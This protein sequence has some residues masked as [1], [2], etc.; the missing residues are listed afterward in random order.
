MRDD[1]TKPVGA[2]M[3]LGGGIAGMQTSLDLAESGI[4]V[5][6]VERSPS[7]GGR[8]AQL[9]KTFPTNDCAMC[10]I[11]PKL[12]ECGRHKDIEIISNSEVVK[13]TGEPG[14]FT[15][16]ILR[17]ANYIDMEKC[18]GCGECAEVCPSSTA[19]WRCARPSISPSNRP[20]QKSSPSKREAGPP[21]AMP[22]QRV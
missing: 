14:H 9:D 5:Y 2:V 16:T 22:A 8:M 20:Y 3:V 4:K 21:A 12:V 13:L 18:T 15:A 11:S 17:H 19:A 1:G 10:I 6:L 7:I